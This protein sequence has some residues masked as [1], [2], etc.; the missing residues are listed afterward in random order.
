MGR[1]IDGNEV[2]EEPMDFNPLSPCGERRAT[3]YRHK[4]MLIISTHSPR[5]GRDAIFYAKSALGYRISTHSPRVGRDVTL[6]Q[7]KGH[8]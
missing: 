3:F 5:V 1:D 4:K 8:M 7:S 2:F 6:G